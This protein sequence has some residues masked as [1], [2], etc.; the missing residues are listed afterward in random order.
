M[1]HKQNLNL[2]IKPYEV[3]IFLGINFLMGYHKLPSWKHYWSC[4]PDLSVPFVAATMT[5]NRFDLILTN[6]HLNDNTLI[7][8]DNND[9]L[10]KL[11]PLINYLNEKCLQIYHGTNQLS[12]DE[13]MILFKGRSTLKQ[14]NPMKPIK[15][16]YKL[17]CLADQ[18]G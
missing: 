2:N 3:L 13:S 14:Y 6:L 7:P 11:K 10:F 4:A 1:A 8:K 17:W 9:K 18:Q 16:G 15:R 5:R 12:I